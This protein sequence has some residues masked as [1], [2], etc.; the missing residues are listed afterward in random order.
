MNNK[1][2]FWQALIFS[3]AIF[4]LGFII[5][6]FVERKTGENAEISILNLELDLMDYEVTT[7]LLSD[8]SDCSLKERELFKLADKIYIEAVEL[9]RYEYITTL[10]SLLNALHRRYDLLRVMLWLESVKIKKE[11]NSNFSTVVYVYEFSTKDIHRESKQ[12]YF[13]NLLYDIK[14]KYGD[15]LI[16]I[17]IAGNTNV[18]SLN[19]YLNYYNVT[20]FPSILI[21]E[22]IVV[23]DVISFQEMENI[24]FNK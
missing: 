24:I 23:D 6:F 8:I 16:L 17:P 2:V 19:L 15:R 10:S 4:V 5:G 21:N 1:H 22:K 13:G 20:S 14:Y 18:D 11:C 7:K 9:E 12:R 3:L